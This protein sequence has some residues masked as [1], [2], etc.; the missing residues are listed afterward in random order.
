MQFLNV[1]CA[2]FA[3]IKHTM[4]W[5]KRQ[6]S[7]ND[8]IEQSASSKLWRNRFNWADPPC[9]RGVVSLWNTVGTGAGLLFLLSS[10]PFFRLNVWVPKV[11]GSH[12]RVKWFL[13]AE[14][15]RIWKLLR[16][17]WLTQ[18]WVTW[19]RKKKRKFA[20]ISVERSAHGKHR[21][22]QRERERERFTQI[23]SFLYFFDYLHCR[24]SVKALKT[25]NEHIQ[26][27]VVKKKSVK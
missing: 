15:C 25:M 26:N 20:F 18:N 12:G 3:A 4:M 23:S 21:W 9:H 2:C 13:W 8:I 16:R 22:H 14:R 27:D 19:W 5:W 6:I 17:W 10:K 7:I 11:W 1:S 24:F